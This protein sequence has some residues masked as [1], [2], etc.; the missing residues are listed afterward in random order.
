MSAPGRRRLGPIAAVALV[1]GN[2]IGSGIFMLPA[3]LAPY[4]WNAVFAWLIT[5]SGAL[6]LAWVFAQLAAQLPQAGGA[7]G[8]VRTTFGDTPA[9]FTSWGYLASVWTANAAITVAAV[10]YLQRLVPQID[11]WP[12][13]PQAGALFFI[14]LF[15]LGNA[16]ALA[17][18][19]QIVSTLIK[20]LPF[21]LVIGLAAWLM[22]TQGGTALAPI[23]TVPVEA[24]ATL[25]AVGITVFALLGLESASVPADAIDDPVRN[26][27]RATL[28]GTAVAGVVTLL[29]SCAVALM[30][31]QATLVSSTA[32]IADFIGVFVGSGAG[33]FVA[34]CAVISCLGA[35]NGY[36]LVGAELP[37]AMARAGSLPAWFSRANARGV[38]THALWVGAAASGAFVLVALSRQGVAA[39]EFVALVSTV[40]A[41]LLYVAVSTAA[42]RLMHEGR[43][44]RRPGLCVA[45]LGALLFA[46][47]TIW[48]CGI[49]A[50]AWSAALLVLG[51]PLRRWAAARAGS[52]GV[53]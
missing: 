10:S 9:F 27:P 17:G 50:F 26:V 4:G 43:V 28:S 25:T 6:C 2:I 46:G 47:V 8:V 23:D 30:L 53:E 39:F 41:L 1:V 38:P 36:L 16:R 34:L 37:A 45:A 52:T 35:L 24:S 49:E 12:F 3:A 15:A 21:V 20:L 44:A 33:S 7:H 11:A 40:T 22:A 32:P 19:I 48:S 5:I 42:L 29:S 13:G 18:G 31:P 14:V 51:W